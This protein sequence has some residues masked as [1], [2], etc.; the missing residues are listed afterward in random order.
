[1]LF[2]FDLDF[3]LWDAG[4]TWC[5]HT[6]PPYHKNNGNIRDAENRLI[7]LYQDVRSI[8]ST[9]QSRS[10]Q[11]AIASRT[12]S[13]EIAAQLLDLFGIGEYFNFRQIY[14]GSKIRHFEILREQT[15]MPYHNMCFF[16]DEHRNVI[17]VAE[18]GVETCLV[19][20]GL[21]WNDIS[22]SQLIL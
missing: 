19:N 4:G 16:D 12:H 21:T 8:L 22:N 15:A 1:M 14:P 3:T 20:D 5:D 2:V 7:Y 10:I 11:M 18:L 13:P 6:T 17:E 9:L